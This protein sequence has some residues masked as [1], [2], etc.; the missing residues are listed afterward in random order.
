M[1]RSPS[2]PLKT[3]PDD[4]YLTPL[5]PKKK[6]TLSLSRLKTDLT[7]KLTKGYCYDK[8]L[9]HKTKFHLRPIGD[10]PE[11][12][13]REISLTTQALDSL[14]YARV[15]HVQTVIPHPVSV[16]VNLEQDRGR[17]QGRGKGFNNFNSPS[18]NSK[19]KSRSHHRP[20][21]KP[22]LLKD[23]TLSHITSKKWLIYNMQ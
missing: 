20:Q 19:N 15:N 1:R 3:Q 14:K 18:Q 7:D 11:L 13:T 5:L 17:G 22:Q 10:N 6:Q 12:F 21:L 23:E 8:M 4:R 2:K 16:K 9:F